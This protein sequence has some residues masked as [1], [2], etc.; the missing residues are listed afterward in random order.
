LAHGREKNIGGEGLGYAI[1]PAEAVEAG[2]GQ[3]DG[4]ILAA[5][6]FAETSVDVAA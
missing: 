3:K 1:T 5:L 6:R 4:V 2:F